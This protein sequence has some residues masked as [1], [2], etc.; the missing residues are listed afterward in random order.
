M[1]AGS[2]PLAQVT[3][4]GGVELVL[5]LPV[6]RQVIQRVVDT[7]LQAGKPRVRQKIFVLGN[8]F[9]LVF[10]FPFI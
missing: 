9:R 8:Q 7:A 1:T 2:H 10:R 3:V 6:G 4:H 5:L